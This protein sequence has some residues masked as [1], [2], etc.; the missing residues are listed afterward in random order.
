MAEKIRIGI[1]AA[2]ERE[3]APLVRGWERAVNFG[4]HGHMPAFR[5]NGAVLICSGIGPDRAFSNTKDLIE[6]FQPEIVLSVGFAGSLRRDLAVGE[7]LIPQQVVRAS[8]GTKMSTAFGHGV[9]VTVDAMA[10][11]GTK[12]ELDRRYRADA[13]D[14]EAAAVAAAAAAHGLRFAAM[15]AV[16]DGLDDELD[17]LAPFVRP[18]GFQ[19]RRFLAYVAVRPKL[20]GV[21]SRLKHNSERA[22]A[23]LCAAIEEFLSAPERFAERWREAPSVK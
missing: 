17:F 7:I 23:A 11:F 1:V 18:E 21:V 3:I 13:V 14:M 9:L 16:S 22:S 2:M 19:T 12:Q 20:W 10:G 15:K 8:D 6:S 5:M 4:T